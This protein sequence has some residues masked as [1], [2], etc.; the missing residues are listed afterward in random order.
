M[1]ALEDLKVLDLTQYEAGTSCTQLLAWLGAEVVKVEQ[2]GV[3]DPGRH[4]ESD[5][6]SIYFLSYNANKRS[7]ALN[8]KT[9]AGRKLFLD[10][11]P[12]FDVVVENF[13]L[14]TMEDLGIGYEVLK[15][16]NPAIIYATIKGFGTYGPYAEFRVFDPI[17]QSTGGALSVTGVP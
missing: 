4:T 13:S 11:V 1:Q 9:E 17:A 7:V 16:A 12:R 6:D 3:G 14:G 8:L 5:G 10:L 2:A 15:Q